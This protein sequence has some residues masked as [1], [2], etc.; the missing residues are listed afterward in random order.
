[1]SISES[2]SST[3]A[4]Y[5][6]IDTLDQLYDRAKY[7]KTLQANIEYPNI[8]SLLITANGNQL[9]LGNR[10][11]VIDR[12][13]A[14]PFAVNTTNNTITVKADILSA[15]SQFDSLVTTGTISIANG[16]LIDVIYSDANSDS[17]LTITTTFPAQTVTIYGSLSDLNTS[18]NPLSTLVSNAQNQAIY[19]YNSNPGNNIY[20]KTDLGPSVSRGAMKKYELVSGTD[21]T[22]NLE[23]GGDFTYVNLQLRQIQGTGFQSSVHSL[24]ASFNSGTLALTQGDKDSIADLAKSKMEEGAGILQQILDTLNDII[25]RLVSIK[26]DTLKIK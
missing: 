12:T 16:A 25:G 4:A 3:V 20:I 17:A 15:G 22:L 7:W 23:A 5:T 19:R 8:N 21:N 13:A 26:D 18:S 24:K 1:M 9:D 10:N 11:L 6:S 14:T 2:N